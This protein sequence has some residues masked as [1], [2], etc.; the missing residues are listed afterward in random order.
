MG[1]AGIVPLVLQ[2]EIGVKSLVF[3][4]DGVE[5]EEKEVDH[6]R[7]QARVGGRIDFCE[8]R[9]PGADRDDDGE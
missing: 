7:G 1:Q 3:L 9:R 4:V 8:R 2:V 6:D 5:V